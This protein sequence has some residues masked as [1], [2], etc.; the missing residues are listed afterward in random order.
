MVSASGEIT[1]HGAAWRI[2]HPHARLHVND[3][4]MPLARQID[5]ALRAKHPILLSRDI[6]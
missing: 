4:L 1:A 6:E 3:K 2:D 5:A